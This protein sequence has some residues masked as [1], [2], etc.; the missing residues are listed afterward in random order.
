MSSELHT[1]FRRSLAFL[2][3]FAVFDLAFGYVA[4][5]VFFSQET[6]KYARVANVI[7]GEADVLVMG[8]SHAN[9]HYVPAVM[10]T[11][12]DASVLNAGAQGQHLLFQTA[13]LK[14][15]LENY[16]PELVILNVDDWWMY[17]SEEAYERLADLHPYYWEYREQLEPAL[18]LEGRLIDVTLL[19]RTYQTNSTIAHAARYFLAPRPDDNGY[20]PL[21]STMDEPTADV[22]EERRTSASREREIDERFV[23][24]F[25]EF[26]SVLEDRDVELIV[27]VSPEAVRIDRSETNYE[28]FETMRSIAEENDVPFL[29]FTNDDAFVEQ[30]HLFYDTSH[31]NDDG[32]RMFSKLVAEHVHLVQEAASGAG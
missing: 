25:E 10:E 11:E 23:S 12:L 32:A 3:F 15:V 28:S 1:F 26:I 16:T 8:S 7:D 20:L 29:D 4:T 18:S 2:V 14:V 22:I 31:L 27:V 5:Q 6:G 9:R 19:S 21:H 30:Y 24:S 17:S 13:L